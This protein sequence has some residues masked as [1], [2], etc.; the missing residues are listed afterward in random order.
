MPFI[1]DSTHMHRRTTGLE[2]ISHQLFSREALA[3]LKVTPVT[4]ASLPGLVSRQWLGLPLAVLKRPGSVVLC[5]GFPPSIALQSVC[6]TIIP[7]VHD[8]LPARLPQL[9]HRG[10]YY[11][12]RPSFL[13]M[14]RDQR[15]FL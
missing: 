9:L 14:L 8:L 3:P 11:Y 2:R 6:R 10:A 12:Y 15:L 1:V 13:R 4:A 7:Y 5:P